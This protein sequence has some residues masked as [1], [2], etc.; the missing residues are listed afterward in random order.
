MAPLHPAFRSLYI[1]LHLSI[2]HSLLDHS[3]VLRDAFFQWVIAH[4]LSFDFLQRIR[5]L[6]YPVRPKYSR[7]FPDDFRKHI[8]PLLRLRVWPGSGNGFFLYSPRRSTFHYRVLYFAE[9]IAASPSTYN[10]EGTASIGELCSLSSLFSESPAQLF[11]NAVQQLA[12]VFAIHAR[13]NVGK[14]C[15]TLDFTLPNVHFVKVANGTMFHSRFTLTL[16]MFSFSKEAISHFLKIL[17]VSSTSEIS[18]PAAGNVLIKAYMDTH[19]LTFSGE[20]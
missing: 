3:E 7:L 19:F 20:M 15:S 12:R 17:S 9:D 4:G 1:K 8:V 2:L 13:F 10:H 18:N 16:S 5:S 14:P 6:E 11:R